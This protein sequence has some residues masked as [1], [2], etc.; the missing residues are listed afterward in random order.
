MAYKEKFTIIHLVEDISPI[1]GGVAT[2]VNMLSKEL[3]DDNFKH[4]VV[5]NFALNNKLSNKVSLKVFRPSKFSLG[6]GFSFNL[7]NF[8]F[9]RA[10]QPNTI[11]HVH[12]V[13][14][15]IHLIGVLASIKNK[16]PILLTL[17]GMMAPMLWNTQGLLKKFKKD[18][19][20]SISSNFFK[21]IKYVHAITEIEKKDLKKNFPTSDISV[22]PNSM[23]IENPNKKI[24]LKVKRYFLFLGRLHPQKGLDIL[25]KAYLKTNLDKNI[26][27]KIVGPVGHEHYWDKIR[28]EIKYCDSIEYLGTKFGKEKEDLIKNAWVCVVPS[29]MEAVGMVN[30]ES[31]NLR[32]PS[33]TTIETGLDDWEEGG[34]V[35]IRAESINDCKE[36]L[37]KCSNWSSKDRLHRGEQSYKL[38]FKKYNINK[39][40]LSWLN[41]YNYLLHR[42]E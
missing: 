10:Q 6:W 26:K 27:L 37:I 3:T 21:K 18:I 38:A 30:L 8:I 34:G 36:A 17:H 13:W 33:I 35:L 16:T 2:V 39:T 25:V 14:K 24:N 41:L 7:L 19:Y 5:C 42:R 32:C 40:N 28:N 22:I 29:R 23:L 31:A 9:K 12:G 11:F 4:E 1:S 15:A 20:W